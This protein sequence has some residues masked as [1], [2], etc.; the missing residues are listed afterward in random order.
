MNWLKLPWAE[1][2]ILVPLVG[3]AV[4]ALIR[5][6]ATAWRW[7]LGFSIAAFCCSVMPWIALYTGHSATRWD[8]L[9]A[10]VGHPVF[11]VDG[12]SAPLLPLVALLHVLTVL[13][14]ARVK[15]NRMSLTGHLA[16]EAVRLA[17]FACISP[18]VLIGLM[19]LGT[20][21]PYLELLQRRSPTRV[22]VLHMLLF[23]VLLVAGWSGVSPGRVGPRSRSCGRADSQRTV[24]FHLW[25]AD[26]FE[27]T[28]FG[29]ALCS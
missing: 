11:A 17:T 9:A 20:V 26:L 10:L 14:T 5:D 16:A 25:V 12:L 28:S 23:S 19:I 2:T 27:H 18:W 4:V 8:P 1:L 22:Y 13:A 29:T 21:P 6:V 7:T 24:P 15:L 3:V